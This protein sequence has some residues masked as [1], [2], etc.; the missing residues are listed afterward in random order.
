MVN[1]NG[2]LLFQLIKNEKVVL[3]SLMKGP[4]Y[5]ITKIPTGKYKL[6]CILDK[7]GDGKWTTGNFDKKQQPEKV[8][9][10]KKE[11]LI[12]SNW[13]LVIEWGSTVKSE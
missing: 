1:L 6:K 3:D 8:I 5:L 11:I 7:N 2:S 12:R 13:D 4:P 9:D 10:Y